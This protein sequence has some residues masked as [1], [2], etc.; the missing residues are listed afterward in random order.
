M[1]PDDP[2]HR[3]DEPYQ[4][5]HAHPLRGQDL[6][7]VAGVLVFT[8]A[9]GV[10]VSIGND[11][12]WGDLVFYAAFVL[13]GFILARITYAILGNRRMRATAVVVT[14]DGNTLSAESPFGPP[15]FREVDLTRVTSV[16]RD[17]DGMDEV[18]VLA[19]GKRAARVPLRATVDPAV[20]EAVDGAVARA[21]QVSEGARRLHAQAHERSVDADGR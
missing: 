10:L 14:L 6:V 7:L 12:L 21:S 13:V 11:R 4:S 20:L 16:D 2:A 9:V 1:T 5:V 15:E 8:C 3:T 17:V 18:F 19:D